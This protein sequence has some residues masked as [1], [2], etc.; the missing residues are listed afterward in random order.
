LSRCQNRLAPQDWQKPRRAL[1]EDR[2]HRSV[3]DSVSSKRFNATA[4]VA[5]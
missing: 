2:N 5:Q 4:V 3:F 1:S